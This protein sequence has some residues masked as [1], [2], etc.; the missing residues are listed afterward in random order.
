MECKNETLRQFLEDEQYCQ[1]PIFEDIRL[2]IEEF[3]LKY[4]SEEDEVGIG[5]NSI[6]PFIIYPNPVKDYIN[7]S[8][9]KRFEIMDMQGKIL[10]KSETAT[11]SV[12]VSGL[13]AGFYLIKFEDNIIVKFI[14]E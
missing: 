4:L 9:K 11:Q 7:F 14:K 1:F 5:Q 12:N 13:N 8:D 3:A 10:L 2:L 6:L